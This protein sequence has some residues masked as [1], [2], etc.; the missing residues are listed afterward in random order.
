[1]T[2]SDADSRSLF[3]LLCF[4]VMQYGHYNLLVRGS[5]VCFMIVMNFFSIWMLLHFI[6]DIVIWNFVMDI[7]I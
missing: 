7:V 4:D 1:M 6:V 2:A 3:N 5:L